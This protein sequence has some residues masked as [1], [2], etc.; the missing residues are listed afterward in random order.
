MLDKEEYTGEWTDLVNLEECE[1]INGF[2]E[3]CLSEERYLYSK[4]L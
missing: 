3:T 2:D 1:S 4:D